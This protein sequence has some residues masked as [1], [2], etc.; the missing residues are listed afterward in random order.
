MAYL[1]N[2]RR[3]SSRRR[4]KTSRRKPGVVRRAARRMSRPARRRVTRR[5]RRRNPLVGVNPVRVHFGPRSRATLSHSMTS[6]WKT[7]RRKKSSV[8]RGVRRYNPELDV[9]KAVKAAGKIGIGYGSAMIIGSTVTENLFPRLPNIVKILLR[10]LVGTG[11][12]YAANAMGHDGEDIIVG[13]LL[14]GISEAARGFLYGRRLP[15]VL[16]SGLEG[17]AGVLPSNSGEVSGYLP[18]P[19]NRLGMYIP[20]R[21]SPMNVTAQAS[22]KSSRFVRS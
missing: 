6:A 16:K 2:P 5:K 22:R 10:S 4:K 13:S 9:M 7:I 3:K 20:E 8:S 17:V 21:V 14:Y 1:M 19:N 15:F 12:G 18:T 11:V